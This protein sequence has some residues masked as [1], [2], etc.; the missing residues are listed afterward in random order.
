MSTLFVV[1]PHSRNGDMDMTDV[2][3]ALASLG[4]V[5]ILRLCGAKTLD[6]V[7][8]AHRERIERIVVAGGDGTL[9]S[10][11]ATVLKSGL[12]L[13][14]IPCGTANDFARSLDL[15][16]DP[17][18]A[19]AQIVENCT[20]RVDVGAVDGRYF[21]NAVSIGLGPQLT[22]Y[23]DHEKKKRLGILAYLGSLVQ[24]LGQARRRYATFTVDGIRERMSFIQITVASGRHY[25]GGMTVSDE[26]KMDDG[27]L[28]L[29][30]VRPLTPLQ[31]FLRALRIKYGAIRDDEKL[32]YRQG[33]EVEVHTRARLDVTADGE[34][35]KKTPIVC[36][37]VNK[38][39]EVFVPAAEEGKAARTG[40]GQ[41]QTANGDSPARTAATN[42][43]SAK[44]GFLACQ[45]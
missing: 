6:E 30:C 34:L 38:A 18:T 8:S 2:A 39:L 35:I 5:E 16:S 27:L 20:R 22:K 32:V 31:L 24:V 37:V 33:H 15:A 13:G 14:I 43:H 1:N 45:Y 23:L 29:L 26:V 11:L 25:G 40:E 28:H 9:N 19:A 21:L 10:V 44:P 36:T 4:D 17:L 7:V 12:P 41:K 42:A 3:K